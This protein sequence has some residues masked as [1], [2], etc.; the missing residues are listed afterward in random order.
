MLRLNSMNK[1]F[2][3]PVVWA[4]V[5][6]LHRF[7]LSWHGRRLAIW[8]LKRLNVIDRDH[9][10]QPYEPRIWNEAY[11]STMLFLQFV[12]LFK[13]APYLMSYANN[14]LPMFLLMVVFPAWRVVEILKTTASIIFFDREK[15]FEPDD[16]AIGNYYTLLGNLNS[17]L[18]M[19][20][21]KWL[22]MILCF[23]ALTLYLGDHW[24]KA[25]ET[26]LNAL[27]ITVVTM[28]T[29]G[30]GD[31]HPADHQT[32]ILVIGKLLCFLIY[33]LLVFPIVAG[34][35]KTRELNRNRT[36]N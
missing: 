3:V 9:S 1:S 13:I 33:L 27:Y 12:N 22:D 36:N 8:L 11:V 4:L 31:F 7:S 24:N 34:S 29:L 19:I 15:K 5:E 21:L 18:I 26:P 17:W 14:G 35:F 28:L 32:R 10:V 20:F 25:V 23:S 30:Y 2:I 6:L 16:A